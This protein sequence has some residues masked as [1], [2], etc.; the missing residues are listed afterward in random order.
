MK[1]F[2]LALFAATLLTAGTETV[3]A[4]DCCVVYPRFPLIRRILF[5]A[6]QF[7][8]QTGAPLV[9]AAAHGAAEGLTSGG[10][11]GLFG[12]EDLL[13]DMDSKEMAGREIQITDRS[14][15]TLTITSGQ[16]DARSRDLN[17]DSGFETTLN[18]IQGDV[19]FLRGKV[20]QKPEVAKAEAD[21]FVDTISDKVRDKLKQEFVTK[22]EFKKELLKQSV[23]D[24]RTNV[25]LLTVELNDSTLKPDVR[26]AKK[27]ELE[28]AKQVLAAAILEANQ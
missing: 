15:R 16:R 4:H 3:K 6:G 12:L 13:K 1:R 8:V 18:Q 25:I 17:K 20:E 26:T 23:V 27:S 9:Q 5:G 24:A 14:G 2:A 7:V 19:A 28:Q 11:G 22:D 10:G 21:A